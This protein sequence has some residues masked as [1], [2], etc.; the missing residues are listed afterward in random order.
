[1]LNRSDPNDLRPALSLLWL[2]AILNM[3]FRDIHEFTMASTLNE[4][5]SG[6]ING[7]PMSETVLLYGAFAVE[8]LL[9]GFLLSAVLP[10]RWARNLN[11]VLVPA[12]IAGMFVVPPADPD[13][14][15][16]AIVEI[17]ALAAAFVLAW[18]WTP[19][20]H[21]FKTRGDGYAV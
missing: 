21:P 14:I 7:N 17:C 10:A 19:H 16:F 20:T 12:A 2:F 3:V 6:T 15:F 18:R 13:D 11:L 4:I 5:L 1:M 8:I 9:L